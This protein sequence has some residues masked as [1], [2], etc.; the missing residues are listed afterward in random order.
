VLRASQ[1]LSSETGLARLTAKVTEVLGALSGATH[2]RL[3]SWQGDGWN[4]VAPEPGSAPMPAALAADEGHIP[5][6]VIAYVERTGEALLVD[7]VSSDDRFARDR[8]FRRVPACSLLVVPIS[9][10]GG[11]RAM[12]YLEN[13]AVRAAFSAG[14]LDAVRLIAG[15]LA[16]SLANAQLYES[17]E[18][19]VAARTRE[20]EQTQAQLVA[21]AR[22]AGKAEIANNVL[23]NVGNVLNSINV[24]TSM[25]RNTIVK[26]KLEGLARAVALMNEI[27]REDAAFMGSDA[28]GKTLLAYL[29]E[30]VVAL[31][32]EREH[33]LADLDRLARS[34]EHITYVVAS[35]QSHAGPSSVVESA[36]PDDLLQ[37]AL[38]LCEETIVRGGVTVSR[39]DTGV[40]SVTLDR[41]RVVQILVNLIRNGVQAMGALPAAD[42]ELALRTQLSRAAAG[43]M[44]RITVRDVGEGIA[45]ED[46]K[47]I[48]SHGF[49]TRTT[50][51]GFGLHS[52]ALAATEMGGR[53]TAH[54]DGR[55]R[56]AS[57]T[58]ELPVNARPKAPPA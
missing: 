17:L 27:G 45:T 11:T 55:G 38:H 36:R 48:F 29:N 24:S 52:S 56:G 6:A 9:S 26:S 28:R 14:R 2:V 1:A 32:S 5:A 19:R 21:T 39:I 3:L 46:L 50:G 23:H 34:V 51:H 12:V 42:R 20:L 53:I 18:E 58:L 47:R 54:S 57:F 43:D 8:Y 16:V 41:Q 13:R 7:D 25:V 22:R 10:Q 35:Q 37:E 15:Q 31:G 30:L 33:A 44:L 49:T 40:P 4:L